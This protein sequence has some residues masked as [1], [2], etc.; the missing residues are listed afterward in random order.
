MQQRVA[1]LEQAT[2][3]R[4]DPQIAASLG[5]A[6]ATVRKWRRIGQRQGR[7]GLASRMGRPATGALGTLPATLRQAILR[8][9]QDHPGWGPVTI[10]AELQRDPAWADTPLPSRARLAA[11]LRE[12][13]LTRSYQKQRPLPQPPPSDP[14]Q[15]HDEWQLDA[16]GVTTV[17]G[18]GPV[19]LINIADVVSRLKIESGPIVT[20]I[21]PATDDYFLMLRRAFASYGLPR[22]ISF[23]HGSVFFDNTTASPFPT[24]L[25]LWLIALDVEVSFTR[26]RQPT[27][28][29]LI[30]RTHQTMTW[31]ALLGQRWG[32][33]ANLWSGLDQRRE[34]LNTLLPTRALGQPPLTAYPTA[35]HS[36][37]RYRPEWEAELLDLRRVGEYLAG[38]EWFRQT[39]PQGQWSL[40]SYWYNLGRQFAR[41][42]VA[43]TFE[44]QTWEWICRPAGTDQPIRFAVKG[45]TKEVLMGDLAQMLALPAYQLTLPF[46]REAWRQLELV[47]CMSDTTL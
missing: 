3:G 14:G 41:R 6:L 11:F 43:I 29:A 16:Q 1:I 28:H 5:L 40:G 18:I 37:R 36:G 15:P 19:C 2:A 7:S 45:L 34:V 9:R 22:R 8:L 17:S 20:R 35:D 21:Q 13:K 46:R 30:E 44:G 38:G 47:R 10:L 25:H 4:T 23:D 27:D 39:N 12:A 24:R 31:Q 42:E 33:Q 32:D 26:K